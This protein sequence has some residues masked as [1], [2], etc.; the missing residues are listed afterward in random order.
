MPEYVV[1]WLGLALINAAIA[2]V[3]ARSP[4][5]CCLASLLLGPLVTLVLAFTREGARGSLHQ[6]HVWGGRGVAPRA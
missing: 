3:D 1:G 2:N 4:L 5:K 6:V